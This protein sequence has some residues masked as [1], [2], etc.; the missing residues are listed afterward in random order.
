MPKF[1][2]QPLDIEDPNWAASSNKGPCR[3]TAPD[4]ESARQIAKFAF[5]QAVR[6]DRNQNTLVSPWENPDLV[7]AKE[8]VQG[9]L[10][11]DDIR[12]EVPS[13]NSGEGTVSEANMLADMPQKSDAANWDEYEDDSYKET[14]SHLQGEVPTVDAKP[15]S[16]LE[17]EDAEWEDLNGSFDTAPFDTTPFDGNV[18]VDGEGN[19]VIVAPSEPTAGTAIGF[20]EAF[21]DAFAKA[22]VSGLQAN[23]EVGNVNIAINDQAAVKMV[24]SNRP[25]LMAQTKVL[26]DFLEGNSLG[27]IGNQGSPQPLWLDDQ[28]DQ[29]LQ[30]LLEQIRDELRRFND[31]LGSAKPN[32]SA[33]AQFMP[34]FLSVGN[35]WL[36]KFSSS[37]GTL[38]GKLVAGVLATALLS[39]GYLDPTLAAIIFGGEAGATA[40]QNKNKSAD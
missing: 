16:P 35:N 12:L 4:E 18:V 3:V 30:A 27:P 13:L 10:Q 7:E 20:S 34:G 8:I 14:F 11:S 28:N 32:T 17:D 6:S 19:T 36:A 26:L 25:F 29:E 23:A 24:I 31:L 37:N 38:T 5:S 33:L 21:S 22:P 15:Q 2:L 39:A 1:E 9:L 40:L